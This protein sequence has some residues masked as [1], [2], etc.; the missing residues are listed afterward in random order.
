MDMQ[1]T[2]DECK[3]I[4]EELI[5]QARDIAVKF[6]PMYKQ[7]D[8]KWAIR[9]HMNLRIPT[10]DEI[11]RAI[12]KLGASIDVCDSAVKSGGLVLEVSSHGGYFEV[13]VRLEISEVFTVD[14]EE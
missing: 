14:I 3:C 2:E 5:E 1:L 8:W 13:D 10:V 6:Q 12:V 4:Q 9:P 11:Q 7:L